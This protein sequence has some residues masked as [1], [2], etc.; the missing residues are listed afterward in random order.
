MIDKDILERLYALDT[1]KN[2]LDYCFEELNKVLIEKNVDFK[3]IL[4]QLCLEDYNFIKHQ[5]LYNEKNK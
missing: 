4:N 3:T 2:Y 1:A 5:N